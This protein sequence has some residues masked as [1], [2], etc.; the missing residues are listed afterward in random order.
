MEM[1]PM[2]PMA[3]HG[4]HLAV[5]GAAAAGVAPL[6]VA[7]KVVTTPVS[8]A[9]AATLPADQATALK[10]AITKLVQDGT[11]R[12]LVGYHMDMSHNMHGS[13]GTTGLHRFL[14]W[15]RRFLVEFEREIHRVDA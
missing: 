3:M 10:N 15:H 9:N 5:E 14:A 12:R 1:P 2:T 6:H 13:M 7:P 11:Y 4:G 8:R